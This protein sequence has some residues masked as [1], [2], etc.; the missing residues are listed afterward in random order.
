MGNCLEWS[1]LDTLVCIMRIRGEHNGFGNTDCIWGVLN[2]FLKTINVFISA[3]PGILKTDNSKMCNFALF[4]KI[5]LRI[6]IYLFNP[7][8]VYV[9]VTGSQSLT[10]E[11]GTWHLVWALSLEK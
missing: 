9:K 6:M 2:K 3:S 10:G 8:R 11:V 7:F 1:I 4:L 5:T